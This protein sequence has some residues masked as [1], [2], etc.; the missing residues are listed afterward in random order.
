MRALGYLVSI[1]LI[2]GVLFEANG[3]ALAQDV[4]AA[5]RADRANHDSKPAPKTDS[6]WFSPTHASIRAQDQG[7]TATIVYEIGAN[8]DL[9]VTMSGENEGKK[10][11][12]EMMLING[13]RPWMLTRN[14][15]MEKGY[16]IDALDAVVLNLKLVLRLLTAAAPGGPA[17]VKEKSTFDVR[18]NVRSIEVNTTSASGGLEAPWTL[19]AIIQKTGVDEWSFDLLAKHAEPIHMTGTWQEEATPRTFRDDLALDGWQIFSLGPMRNT[20]GGSTI[21]DYGAQPSRLQP[22]TLG[23]LRKLPGS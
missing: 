4:A 12:S 15:P 3:T 2:A 6:E 5:A 10:Q 8:Q 21:F 11:V 9:K 22:K 20:D 19:H 1:A 13:K 7:T 17:S 23:E 14:V 16:E 18:E